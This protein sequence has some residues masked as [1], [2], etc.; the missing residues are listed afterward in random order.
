[1][2]N[3]SGTFPL[4]MTRDS[5]FQKM[6]DIGA[7]WTAEVGKSMDISY[8][9]M[10]SGFKLPTYFVMSQISQ[11]GVVNSTEL[12]QILWDMFG[13][14]WERLWN[15]YM[16]EYNPIDNYNLKETISR[17]QT[18][19]RDIQRNGTLSSTVDN[20]DEETY[21][22]QGTSALQHGQTLDTTRD[23]NDYTYG[24]N[25]TEKVPTAVQQ[26]S[27]SD[28]YSGTDTTTTSDSGKTD[29]ASKSVRADTTGETTSDDNTTNESIERTR[30]G[31]IGQNS[32]QELLSK[33]F[34]L[35]KWN[36]F[37]NVFDDCDKF[38]CITIYD[39]CFSQL[40]SL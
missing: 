2:N 28:V 11:E 30:Q 39:P 32:Y 6:V 17:E 12:A 40:N 33:E 7:P 29:T 25:S 21:S 37:T 34:E 14:N 1:M 13:H 36:F 23:I 9:T 10:Y 26:Q 31:N 16:L 3:M 20:T 5:L 38:L 27:G 18:D 19:N 4:F 8:F 15:A 24:F 22:N 35:W